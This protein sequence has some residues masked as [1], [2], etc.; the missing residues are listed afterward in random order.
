[1]EAVMTSQ[2][3]KTDMTTEQTAQQIE[4]AAQILR[5]GHPLVRRWKTQ[6]EKQDAKS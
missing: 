6:P 3:T 5:V 1:M 2:S 4:L